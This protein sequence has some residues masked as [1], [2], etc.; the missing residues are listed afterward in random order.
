MSILS[1]VVGM[2]SRNAEASGSACISVMSPMQ[3]RHGEQKILF[4][5][6]ENGLSCFHLRRPHW[7]AARCSSWIESVPAKWRSRIVLHQHPQLVRKYNLAGFHGVP[8]GSG[9]NG[10]SGKMFVQCE[11]YQ[12]LLKVGTSCRRIALGPVFPP[13]K[14]DVTV[15][16]RTLSEYAAI[17]AYWK[18]QG[19][20]A[21]IFAFGGVRAEGLRKCREA[22]FSGVVVVGA[23]WDARD[24][25]KA[26]KNLVRKW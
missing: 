22:G 20:K 2:V 24:P 23:V 15:P 12:D 10:L 1:R 7:T 21:E 26:F 19:G 13:E 5:L 25:V 14:Y 11:N 18:K 8:G 16:R 9:G 6:F 4:R 17:A 3:E